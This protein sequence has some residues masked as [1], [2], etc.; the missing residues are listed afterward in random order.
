M[1]QFLYYQIVS[2]A[3]DPQSFGFAVDALTGIVLGHRPSAREAVL[4]YM[5]LAFL[6][7]EDVNA[8][9]VPSVISAVKANVAKADL[10]PS[11]SIPTQRMDLFE[12]LF[13]GLEAVAP[14]PSA[15][16]DASA[17]SARGGSTWLPG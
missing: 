11:T 2:K 13:D 4:R 14:P 9:E 12:L 5:E 1:R 10:R 16:E 8:S 15:S 6:A 7:R 17:P 3:E